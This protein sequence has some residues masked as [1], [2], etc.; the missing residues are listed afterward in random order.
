VGGIWGALA[1]GLWATTSVN[2]AGA[3]GLFYGNPGQFLIQLKAVAVTVAYSAVASYVLLKLVDKTI[4][5][6]ATEQSERIG[7]DLT[8]H[9]ETGYTML[10]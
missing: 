10:D 4:G 2:S 5:L 3:N 1:T 7:L 6:R 8:D 9:R